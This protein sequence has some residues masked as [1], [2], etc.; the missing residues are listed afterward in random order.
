MNTSA[1][2]MDNGSGTIKAGFVDDTSDTTNEIPSTIIPCIVGRTKSPVF[3]GVPTAF[4]AAYELGNKQTYFGH[5]ATKGS[6]QI[7]HPIQHGKI[8]HWDDLQQLWHYIFEHH[9]CVE[10]KEHSVLCTEN[11]GH[12]NRGNREKMTEIMFEIFDVPYL[13]V[14]IPSVLSLYAAG[15]DTGLVLDS[16]F[17]QTSICAIYEGYVL[18]HASKTISLSGDVITDYFHSIMMHKGHL[19]T[20]ERKGSDA[21]RISNVIKENMCHVTRD[22]D[23]YNEVSIK[24]K[25]YVLPDGAVIDV[26][27]ERIYAPEI[28]F[29][30]EIVD[31]NEDGIH[32]QICESI[33]KCDHEIRNE[34]FDNIVLS[35]GNTMFDG[36]AERLTKEITQIAD[37]QMI[38]NGYM[39]RYFEDDVYRD[40]L[41][42]IYKNL[43]AKSCPKIKVIAP[44]KR[45]YSS[46][47]GGSIV[48]QLDTFSE[49]WI[50]EDEYYDCGPTIVHRKCT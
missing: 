49:M 19:F 41:G 13:Y 34:M 18:P 40:I 23:I 4:Q 43:N 30:P 12:H 9:L 44:P 14:A 45:N 48:A 42:I 29:D 20:R 32:K 28:L 2:V 31:C 24:Q 36:I 15:R 47:I 39:R 25:S 38:I 16:G 46:W 8:T 35:G 21:K 26:E 27:M 3:N 11:I 6:L 7:N 1:I 33:V 17:S 22:G 10:P 5:E 37:K 50:T